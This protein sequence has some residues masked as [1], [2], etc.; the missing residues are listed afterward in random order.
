[1]LILGVSA[2]FH[3]A[4]AAVVRDGVVVAAAEEERF[5]RVKHDPS[6][7]EQAIAWCLRAAG[8]SPGS[9]VSVVY[10]EKPFDTFGRVIRSSAEAGLGGFRTF[11]AAI[12][13]WAKKK[14]W[15]AYELEMALAR[16]GYRLLGDVR[17]AEHHISHA[18]CAFYP[19]PFESATILTV[20]GVGERATSSIASGHGR[21][22]ELHEELHYPDSL[23]L[24]YSVFTDLCGF[25][26]NSG[27]Y[28]LM[29]LAPYG[30]PTYVERILSEMVDLHDDGSFVI[31]RRCI[32]YIGSNSMVNRRV[33]ELF[34]GPRRHPDEPIREREQ[35]IAC[36][37]QVV[38]E[39]ILLRMARH[40]V[41]LTGLKRA[42]L[43]GGV[44]MNSAAM[45]R[46][47]RDGPFDDVW[48]P[49]APGD[50]GGAVGAALWW[51]HESVGCRHVRRDTS[52]FLGPPTCEGDCRLELDG[53]GA[54]YQVI[55]DQRRLAERI[56]SHLSDGAVVA[57]ARGRME[58]GPRALGARSILADP[59]DAGI[60]KR[61]NLRTKRR[62]AFRPFAPAVV[63]EDASDWFVDPGRSPYM[64]FVAR[65]RPPEEIG[66]ALPAVTHVDGTARVQTVE[67]SASPFF[68][69]LLRAFERITSVPVLL[70]TS[71]NV[72]GEPIVR[73]V[74]DAYRCFMTTD[75]DILV[76]EDALLHRS[77]QPTWSGDISR[78]DSD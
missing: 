15:I 49:S 27:E 77:D 21:R 42:V 2:Y 64:G 76:V 16:L 68:H 1:M 52:A 66:V 71:F 26:V 38:L 60:A 55:P 7:P 18:A 56:A 10:Y 4:A 78:L 50:A 75:I 44:A 28:K 62:E 74:E 35:D 39:E 59:R 30:K 25:R 41:G 45:G 29:G 23:G 3:D 51:Y 57:I 61:L 54:V 48:V 73:T 11:S 6:L 33:E 17:F 37:A 40:A 53:L 5:S 47:R 65:V 58:F 70:N 13:V 36:S 12:R 9:P 32:G 20:D 8:V 22:I 43:G 24:L 19:S 72:R 46:L 31:N 34:D 14:L 67:A 63:A 69:G